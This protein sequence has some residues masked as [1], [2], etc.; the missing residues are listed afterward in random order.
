[1]KTTLVISIVFALFLAGCDQNQ[2]LADAVNSTVEKVAGDA[3]GGG[4]DTGDAALGV[5]GGLLLG[6]MM[7]GDG[8]GSKH[9]TTTIIKEKKV[10]VQPSRPSSS[11]SRS[12][13]RCR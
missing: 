8:G 4:I 2:P 7:S 9:H 12:F 3:G 5:V 13:S 11:S 6:S 1:M 10:Y